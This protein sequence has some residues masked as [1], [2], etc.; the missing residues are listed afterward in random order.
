MLTIVAFPATESRNAICTVSESSNICLCL[1]G[2]TNDG[3]RILCMDA[4]QRS[5][6]YDVQLVKSVKFT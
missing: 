5:R 3:H 6:L 1:I 4:K 2:S